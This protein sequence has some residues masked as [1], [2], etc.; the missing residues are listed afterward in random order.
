MDEISPV[1]LIVKRQSRKS[2][3]LQCKHSTRGQKDGFTQVREGH[4]K[5]CLVQLMDLP[6]ASY[7]LFKDPTSVLVFPAADAVSKRLNG[8]PR[9]KGLTRSKVSHLQ[10]FWT[11]KRNPA[12]DSIAEGGMNEP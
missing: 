9:R 6:S 1:L 4:S 11:H 7:L 8:A 5:V 3:H 10:T 2:K 12:P